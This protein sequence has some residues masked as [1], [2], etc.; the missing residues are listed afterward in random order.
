MFK[1]SFVLLF[2]LTSLYAEDVYIQGKNLYCKRT[3]HIHA[4]RPLLKNVQDFKAVGDYLLYRQQGNLFL[5]DYSSRLSR[6]LDDD[7]T[8]YDVSEKGTVVFI[9]SRKLYIWR[10]FLIGKRL[11][12]NNPSSVKISKK[13][14][15]VAFYREGW[16]YT[17]TDNNTASAKKFIKGASKY[18]LSDEGVLLFELRGDVFVRKSN[19][20]AV[21]L[22]KNVK[23]LATSPD[24]QAVFAE[25]GKLYVA[26]K[27]GALTRATKGINKIEVSPYGDL[28]G[29]SYSSVYLIFSA[30]PFNA[31]KL[32][33]YYRSYRFD[34]MG[35]IYL[36]ESRGAKVYQRSNNWTYVSLGSSKKY[37][38]REDGSLKIFKGDSYEFYDRH[39][40]KSSSVS[41]DNT[42]QVSDRP[43]VDVPSDKEEI[44]ALEGQFFKQNGTLYY[45]HGHSVKVVSDSVD[46]HYVAKSGVWLT[47][48][49][50]L[51]WWDTRAL[52][53][54][55]SRC[56][57]VYELGKQA[58][59]MKSE[60]RKY[61][62]IEGELRNLGEGVDKFAYSKSGYAYSLKGKVLS[63]VSKEGVHKKLHLAVD[64]LFARGDYCFALAGAQIYQLKNDQI[65]LLGNLR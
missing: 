12:M 23:G 27:S 1:Y 19:G 37:E 20:A 46:K 43:V 60:G 47:Q 48:D 7:V 40:R 35:N 2:I 57:D 44:K 31:K 9:A 58:Y 22:R 34:K 5:Y 41:E 55:S 36:E 49:H 14:D 16:L 10:N 26:E 15:E 21:R 6:Y 50:Y 24:G 25:D 18:T 61:L 39:G 64:D 11:V 62:M 30:K 17:I 65:I 51:Y 33:S 54:I 28:I 8:A 56:T 29:S 13:S 38:A 59:A 45:R 32:S 63:C 53:K 3:G 52:K 4:S 42:S